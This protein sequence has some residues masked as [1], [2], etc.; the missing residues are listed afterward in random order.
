M[1]IS[2]SGPDIELREEIEKFNQIS[3]NVV[4][5]NLSFALC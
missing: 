2:T 1:A 4:I 3:K 5:S